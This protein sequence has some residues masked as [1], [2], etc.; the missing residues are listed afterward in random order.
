MGDHGDALAKAISHQAAAR[1]TPLDQLSPFSLSNLLPRNEFC[2][3]SKVSKER[4]ITAVQTEVPRAAGKLQSEKEVIQVLHSQLPN[5][6]TT[7]VFDSL[8]KL[9]DDDGNSFTLPPLPGG[10]S[11]ADHN[12][13]A[14][15][16]SSDWSSA[17]PMAAELC[18]NRLPTPGELGNT[19]EITIGTST[20]AE[21]REVMEF[22][23]TKLSEGQNNALSLMASDTE[24]VPLKVDWS[25][26]SGRTKPWQALLF[27]INMEALSGAKQ[28]EFTIAKERVSACNLPTRFFFGTRDW[29]IHLR[30]P[31][32]YKR[33]GGDTQVILNLNT[34]LPEEAKQLLLSL[35]PMIGSGIT[36]DYLQWG[37]IL[38][39]VWTSS[40]FKDMKQPIELEHL[41]RL[42]R[43]NTVNS[44]IFFLNWWCLGTVIPKDK[45][46]LGDKKWGLPLQDIP[47][48]LR[49]YLAVDIVQI[50]KVA[51]VLITTAGLQT[52]PDMTVVREASGLNA[53]Q[54]LQWFAEKAVPTLLA[55]ILVVF[56]DKEGRPY[57]L[58]PR[59]TWVEQ[60]SAAAMV[61]RLNPPTLNKF[62]ALWSIPEWPSVTCGGPRSIHQI[63]TSFI[64]VLPEFQKLDPVRWPSQH[65]DKLLFW[66]FGVTA[67]ESTSAD[68]PII[69]S[70]FVRSPGLVSKL[71]SNPSQWTRLQFEQSR[72][73]SGR[74]DRMLI[75]EFIRCHP[76]RARAVLDFMENERARFKFLVGEARVK[77]IVIDTRA[78]LENLNII[79]ERP[80]G[81]VDPHSIDDLL[82]RWNARQLKHATMRL[83]EI[84]AQKELLD[85]K[86]AA[87]KRRLS[88]CCSGD[89]P[90]KSAKRARTIVQEPLVSEECSRKVRYRGEMDEILDE[91]VCILEVKDEE[92]KAIVPVATPKPLV[93]PA[94]AVQKMT[95]SQAVIGQQKP[96]APTPE[97]QQI[98]I[99][100]PQM[101][102]V[103]K[104]TLA[105]D[106]KRFVNDLAEFRIT[107]EDIKVTQGTFWLNGDVISAYLQ[108]LTNRG[109]KN[110]LPSV[111]GL[112]TLF[113]PLLHQSGYCRVKQFTK[114]L[115]IF[116]LDLVLVP[117]HHGL[118]WALVAVDLKKRTV[119]YYDSMLRHGKDDSCVG[120]VIRYLEEEHQHRKGYRMNF[121]LRSMWDQTVP[122]QSNGFDCGVF[123][124][125]FAEQLSRGSPPDATQEHMPLYRQLMVWEIATNQL[126]SSPSAE[127]DDDLIIGID[128]IEM[129][130]FEPE[131]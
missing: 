118:H 28:L 13:A 42:A 111:L 25:L 41:A 89:V 60:P 33:K 99:I 80:Q 50:L 7:S 6:I 124:C 59:I 56:K 24:S 83:N 43:V 84:I 29:Q 75:A 23:Q 54:F 115:D 107:V 64:A 71:D 52:V 130:D 101:Q 62:P 104:N 131:D 116:S 97:R 95:Y 55:G 128:G 72:T 2:V 45:A 100:T 90:A 88:A 102:D 57:K 69:G 9:I 48:D 85:Q 117:I 16:R 65:P 82:T 78:T 106:P 26:D 86:L 121:Q 58:A 108:L 61:T 68:A 77:K 110:G 123:V 91:I 126:Y 113:Y 51:D 30:L 35:P 87:Q 31:V 4:F 63:R 19:K 20:R 32:T 70:G 114:D 21:W 27:H 11:L 47:P 14:I 127:L 103:I 37:E 38:D 18:A 109:G 66:S 98:P 122:Q 53:L 12:L 120:K 73:C 92:D 46:S 10:A 34:V 112:N 74:S 105:A 96:K 119:T 1:A 76:D 44:G 15:R 49:P 36:D 39:A 67:V 81:W 8:P 129:K 94:P 17:E 93:K 3:V 5:A 40:F 79:V 125:R 22:V